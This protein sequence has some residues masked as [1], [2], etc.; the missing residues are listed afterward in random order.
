MAFRNLHAKFN[1]SNSYNN[2]DLCV[3]KDEQA[4]RQKV[5]KTGRQTGREA[6]RAGSSDSTSNAKP[7]YIH[8]VGAATPSAA[9]FEHCLCS[10]ALNREYCIS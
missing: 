10:N 7:K 1:E 4:D 2:W 8:F 5:G 6:G 9:H 3:C